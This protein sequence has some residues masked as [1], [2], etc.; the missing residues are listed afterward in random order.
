VDIKF[1]WITNPS[2]QRAK[3]EENQTLVGDV[4]TQWFMFEVQV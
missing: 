1:L 2:C 3:Y 4:L